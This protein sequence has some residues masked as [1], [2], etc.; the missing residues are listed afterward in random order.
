[1]AKWVSCSRMLN[2]SLMLAVAAPLTLIGPTTGSVIMPG[3]TIDL[4]WTGGQGLGRVSVN[5]TYERDG[6]TVTETVANVQNTGFM[7]WQAPVHFTSRAVSLTVTET[8]LL[9]PGDSATTNTF[10]VG[11]FAQLPTVETAE[12]RPGLV[13][14]EDEVFYYV[15]EQ[16]TV[17]PF[18][19]WEIAA[20]YNHASAMQVTRAE[21]AQLPLGRPMLPAVGSYVQFASVDGVWRVDLLHGVERLTKVTRAPAETKIFPLPDTMAWA[22]RR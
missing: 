5:A 22:L 13:I 1:M 17:R 8:D 11:K 19:T 20:T 7:R 3:Q 16:G 12:L 10:T 4:S 6:A 14:T 18:S 15:T 21:L 9:T 2:K